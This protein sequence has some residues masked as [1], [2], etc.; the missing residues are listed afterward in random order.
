MANWFHRF[1][2]PHCQ[3]C[4]IEVDCLSCETLKQQ[5]AIANREK[6]MLLERILEKPA[7]IVE[8]NPVPV[9]IPKTIPWRVRQQMLESES[10]V[11]ARL[12]KEAPQPDSVEDLEKELDVVEKE[13]VNV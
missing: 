3:H 1:F 8:T 6:E 13:R 5:L 4:N 2:N 10:K 11:K 12:M 9:T 7:P